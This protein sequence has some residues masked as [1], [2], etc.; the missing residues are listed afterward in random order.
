MPP[1]G[2]G[3]GCVGVTPR[4]HCSYCCDKT[5]SKKEFEEG[6]FYFW[7]TVLKVKYIVCACV[8]VCAPS[9]GAWR[10]QQRAPEPL[11]AAVTG[12]W[13]SWR[14]WDLLR[15][16]WVIGGISVVPWHFRQFQ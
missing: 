5:P 1:V 7:L 8:G 6:R 11:G 15:G 14:G 13:A 9:A 4:G 12:V 2:R 16:N 10:V 3:L